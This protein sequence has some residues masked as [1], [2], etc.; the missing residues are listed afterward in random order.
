MSEDVYFN[1][2][3]YEQNPSIK[4]IDYI[5]YN[6]YTNPNSISNTSHKGL[7]DDID[8]LGFLDGLKSDSIKNK[9]LHNYFLIRYTVW[10]LLYSGKDTCSNVFFDYYKKYFKWLKTN[11]I[12]LKNKNIKITGPKGEDKKVGFIIFAFM[13]MHKLRLVKAFSKLY[14]KGKNNG[15]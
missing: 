4:Y 6:Y 14:C 10:Y 11:G 13:I 12:E 3:V 5:G 15:K 1:I 2:K 7:S 8:F 9:E